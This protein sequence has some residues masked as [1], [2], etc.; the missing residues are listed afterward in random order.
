M[1]YLQNRKK[2]SLSSTKQNSSNMGN[3]GS[4]CSF[5]FNFPAENHNDPWLT[6]C[7]I[8]KSLLFLWQDKNEVKE[9]SI[10]K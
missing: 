7:N 2:L 10:I 1:S 8:N 4:Y 3:N 5:Y 6:N 9:V